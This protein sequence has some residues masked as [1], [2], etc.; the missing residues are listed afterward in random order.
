MIQSRTN[1]KR[2]TYQI[3]Y[4]D[5]WSQLLFNKEDIIHNS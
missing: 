5:A 3:D 4:F 2:E 1:G